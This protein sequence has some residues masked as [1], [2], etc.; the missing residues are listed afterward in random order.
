MLE[1]KNVNAGYGDLQVLFD[2]SLRVQPGECVALVGSNGA[3]KTSLLRIISG[4]LPIQSGTVTYEGKDL[5]SQPAHQR[6]MLGIAHIPQGRGI[7]ASLSV[8]DNLILGGYNKRAKPRRMENIEKSFEMFPRLKERRQ[9]IAGS[10]SGGEQQM[11]AI[12]RALIM[13]PSL[14]MLD[15]PSLGL[16][17]IVVEEV[18]STIGRICKTGMSV[19]IIE[20]NLIAALS[21]ATRGYAIETGRV[22]LE[23]TSQELLNNESIKK[24]YL[25]I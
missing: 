5:L 19:L 7:C 15:E 1:M 4:L 20:Q 16:A 17:P 10:L 6:A 9:Q 11:L 2:V 21:I 24:A 12:A 18:F 22:V 3:G 23:G 8:M 25:G 14:L 13:E